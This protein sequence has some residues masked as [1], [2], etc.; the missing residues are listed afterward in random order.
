MSTKTKSFTVISRV[1][2]FAIVAFLVVLLFIVRLFFVQVVDGESYKAQAEGQYVPVATPVFDRGNIFL[3]NKTNDTVLFASLE[4]YYTLAIQPNRV[5][6]VDALILELREAGVVFD[7]A[8]VRERAAKKDDP[9]EE[10]AK[11]V[12]KE[13]VDVLRPKKISGLF[14]NKN[15]RRVYPL[16]SQGSQ[17]VG[18]V[19]N[20]GSVLRG[21]YGIERTY[22]DV[23]ERTSRAPINAFADVFADLDNAL[24]DTVTQGDVDLVATLD[25]TA[26]MVLHNTLVDIQNTWNPELVGGIIM[27]PHTGKIIAMD[28]LPSYDPNEYSEYAN[29]R[30]LNPNVQSVFEMGSIIKA[31]TVA[32]GIDAGVVTPE[33]TFNDT[34]FVLL[35][36]YRISN[37]DKKVRGTVSM[38]EVLSKSLNTGVTFIMQKMGPEEFA[39]YFKDVYG[40]DQKT[41]IDLPAEATNL[42]KNLD[43]KEVV[44]YATASFGQGIALSPISTIRA[45]A[46]LANGGK[47]VTPHVVE[48]VIKKDG[49]IE[50]VPQESPVQVLDPASS[51]AVTRMLVKVVDTELAQG[52]KSMP[53][54]SVAA[55]TGTA[56]IP[57]QG[58]G[59]RE[60]AYLHS[61]FGYYPAYDPRFIVLLYQVHPKGATYASQTLTDGFFDIASSLLTY[62][63]VPPDRGEKVR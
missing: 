45:L 38:Q 34:G 49:S 20:D 19:G 30:Y 24:R 57:K 53:E 40:F 1:N 10:I 58:G 21:Q 11:N 60:D 26:L 35:N 23:L 52:K 12:T 28:S 3:K 33:T 13:S 63:A 29:V 62:F 37:F 51:E 27:D 2:V 16:K 31:L 47:L 7:E 25:P 48:E 46:V 43:T 9:Y 17:V 14:F 22:D 59:Y 39:R 18:F 44:N 15:F 6:D 56:Q 42:V 54:Y 32:A 8:R 55:K 4:E 41:G 50:K 5:R 61:F 36:G